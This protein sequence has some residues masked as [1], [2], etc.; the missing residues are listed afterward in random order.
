MKW[1][2]EICDWLRYIILGGIRPKLNSQKIKKRPV[3]RL[4]SKEVL[5]KAPVFREVSEAEYNRAFKA[6]ASN[7]GIIH[8]AKKWWNEQPYEWCK[9]QEDEWKKRYGK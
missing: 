3:K 8:V 9:K 6:A 1:F 2:I 7:M 4:F 5:D